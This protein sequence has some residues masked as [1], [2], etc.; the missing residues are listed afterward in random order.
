MKQIHGSQKRKGFLAAASGVVAFAPF[1]ALGQANTSSEPAED[2]FQLEEIVVTAQK[3]TESAQTVP[4]SIIAL[5]GAKLAELGLDDPASLV[6]HVPNLQANTAVGG[7][8]PVFSMRGVSMSDFSLNQ[9]SPVASYVDE[10]YKGNFALFGVQLYDLERVEVLRGPQGTLYGKN[11]TGGAINFVTRRPDFDRNGYLSAGFGNYDR[12]E[13][14]G[15]LGGSLVDGRLAGRVALTYTDADGWFENRYPGGRDLGAMDER[16][17]RVS[18][19]YTPSDH[20]DIILR[21]AKSQQ[22]PMNYGVYGRPGEFGT[23]GGLYALFNALD[24]VANPETDHFR[25]GLGERELESNFSRRRYIRADSAALTL[26]WRFSEP[27]A[28]TSITSWDEGKMRNPEDTDGSPLEVVEVTYQASARQFTQDLRVTSDLGGRF[29]FIAGLY[30]SRD[31]L[32]NGTDLRFYDDLDVNLDGLLSF[33]DCLYSFNTLVNADPLDDLF[34]AACRVVNSFEQVRDS[35]ALYF[36]GTYALTDHLKLR[37]GL[38]ATHD[39]S[40][41]RGFVSQLHGNDGVVLANLIPGDENDVDA[42]VS[43]AFSDERLSGKLGLDYTTTG[44]TLFYA[45]YSSAFRAGAFNAQAFFAPEELTAVKPENLDAFEIGFKSQFAGGRLQL[46]GA[47]FHYK[48]ENQQFMDVD[49]TTA[50][51]LL[52]N[53]GE[54]T[55]R[56]AELEFVARPLAAVTVRGGLGWLDTKVDRGVLRGENLSGNELPL[57]PELSATLAVDWEAP[58]SDTLDLAL[59]LGGSYASKQYFDILNVERIASDA[60]ALLDA[61]VAIRSADRRWE[62]AAWGKNLT[63]KRY[64]TMGL[65]LLGFGYDYFQLGTPRT[66]GLRATLNF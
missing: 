66:Y 44:G 48:Y 27:Y 14:E 36:D 63:D 57:A 30:L 52:V 17:G 61:R 41:L 32:T 59:Q 28:L 5:S 10:V 22:N 38:R 47:A 65:D 62:V 50:L 21:L 34:P 19:L 16:A 37:A 54:S 55:I 31:E 1:I 12:V 4:S 25:S 7:G 15:A 13:V 26:D 2:G 49:P 51:Q 60:Y 53:I 35:Q 58:L 9:S 33:E 18:L 56:G 39:K 23:G 45:S 3:R 40:K 42:A 29:D 64:V 6:A 20:L 11:T 43:K 8:A 24:P 46:N